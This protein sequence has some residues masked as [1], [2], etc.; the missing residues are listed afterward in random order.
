VSERAKYGPA[1]ALAVL[2]G[3]SMAA[4]PRFASLEALR[5]I[6][7]QAVPV[8][9]AGVGMTLVIASRGI[10]LSVGSVM[11]V[12]AAAAAA[13]IGHGAGVAV[14]AG[15]AAAAALGSVNGLLIARGRAEPFIVT[16]ALLLAGRGLAQVICHEGEVVPFADPLFEWLGM[17]RVGP[18]PVP[19][20]LAALAVA[21][22]LFLARATTFG[23]YLA[24]VGGNEAAARLAGVPVVR[25]R[26]AAY[27]ICA[28]LAGVAG[29]VE[30]A[31]LGAA[32]PSNLGG[33]MEFAAI[34]AA[35]IGGTPL[36]GGRAHVGGTAIGALILAVLA[37]SFNMLLVPFAWSLAVQAAIILLAVYA[38]RPP[39]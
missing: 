20:L 8:V 2:V 30:T 7:L 5:V 29:L 32:D 38:Q 10:D 12:A 23:R 14:L 3:A 34:F 17:G 26:L 16:L 36:H 13:L 1:A 25:T 19:V 6:A 21:G 37:A 28:V 24:A 4:V 27:V 39:A 22:G 31:R 18:L 35:V 33:G 11:A 9:L 15:L